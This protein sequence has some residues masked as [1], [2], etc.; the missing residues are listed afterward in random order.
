MDLADPNQFD[1]EV[2]IAWLRD[3]DG[4]IFDEV[5][6]THEHNDKEYVPVSDI[7]DTLLI[8][9]PYAQDCYEAYLR[10]K[11]AESNLESVR[12]N[13]HMA[14]YNGAYQKFVNWYNRKYMPLPAKGG[15]RFRF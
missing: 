3:L 10:A 2:K 14:K 13:Q 6:L 7:N 11:M 5:V 4:Q 1:A 15:N 12:F 9:E 8:P